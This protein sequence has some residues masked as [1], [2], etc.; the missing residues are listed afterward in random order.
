MQAGMETKTTTSAQAAWLAN[1][2]PMPG[3]KRARIVQL[4]NFQL[5]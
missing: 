2:K 4:G 3:I 5:L 1:T